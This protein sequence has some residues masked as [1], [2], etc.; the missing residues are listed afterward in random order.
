MFSGHRHD[1][2]SSTNHSPL[3]TT[4][5]ILVANLGS[6]SF[7]YRLFDMAGD[8]QLARGSIE[9]IGSPE[10]RC[11]VEIGGRRQEETLQR[12]RSCRGGPP[13]PGPIDR[14]ADRL[15]QG[16]VGGVGHRL[17]GGSRGR[18]TGVQRV[19]PEVLAAMEEVGRVAPAH[20]PPYITAMRLLG[21][22]L[23]EIPLVAAFETDFHRTIPDAN[24][25]YAVPYDW[26]EDGLIRR[27]GF[28]GASHRYI[29]GRDGRVARAGPADHF[30]P[31]GRIEFALRDPQRPKRGH[32]HGHEPAKRPA[33][34][35]PRRR[36]RSLRPA[37][38]HAAHRQVARRSA[39]DPR[40]PKRAAG[41]QRRQR[42]LPRHRR[43]RRGR[44]RRG[45][46]W[47]STFSSPPRG[48]IWGPIWSNW[49]G[50]TRSSSPAASAR[51]GRPSARPSAATWKSWASCSTR[52]P[53]RRPRARPESVRRRAACRSGSCPPTKS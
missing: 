20:N 3:S 15:P 4:M 45:P 31:P 42:R 32:Q 51:T 49:A 5:K 33:A 11:V 26:A 48:T 53:T 27:H 35:Q 22:K 39:L 12:A 34:E 29:A 37:A 43:G 13:L 36:F 14:S 30:L 6:T 40:Q 52:R 41:P 50:P 21:E 46:S 16:G 2:Q 7:K 23:P 47:P 9:R 44:Q 17:Q 10:S 24:R 1:G 28:H 8:V 25:F 19:T 18:V 38:D